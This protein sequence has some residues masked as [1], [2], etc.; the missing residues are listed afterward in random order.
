[1][2]KNKSIYRKLTPRRRGIGGFSQL[3]LASDHILLVRSSRFVEQYRRF[4]LADIQAIVV[5]P[6]ADHTPWQLA[7]LG[8]S[9]VWTLVFL[10]VDSTAG[11]IFF[12]ATGAIAIGFSMADIALGRRCRCYL[13]TAVTRELLTPVSRLRSARAFLER[14]RPAIEAAQGTLSFDQIAA[15]APAVTATPADA[16]PEVPQAPGYLPEALFGLFLVNA[17]F[18]LLMQRFPNE[19]DNVL[20]TTFFGEFVILIFA[21]ARRGVRDPRRLV[22]ALMVIALLFMSWDAVGLARSFTH[23]MGSVMEQSRRGRPAPPS[24]TGWVAF[25]H[26]PAVLAAGWR[27]VAGVAGLVAA[28]FERPV[29]TA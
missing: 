24:L 29:K 3:W 9:I 2:A 4:A 11:K 28:W 23:Y 6:L 12:G 26:A 14:I 7:A 22:Y 17:V 21:L 8:A 27:M 13:H 1:M 15:I 10:V 16:P 18:V 19:L 5:T 25:E 20:P